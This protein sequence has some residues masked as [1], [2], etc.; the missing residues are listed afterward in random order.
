MFTHSYVHPAA[1]RGFAIAVATMLLAASALIH[2]SI[3]SAA[4]AKVGEFLDELPRGPTGKVLRYKLQ[5]RRTRRA[6]TAG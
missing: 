5:G 2:A 6:E 4:P 3:A 1:R